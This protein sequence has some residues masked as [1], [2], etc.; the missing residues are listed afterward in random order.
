MKFTMNAKENQIKAEKVLLDTMGIGENIKLTKENFKKHLSRSIRQL[1][2]YKELEEKLKNVDKYKLPYKLFEIIRREKDKKIKTPK[3]APTDGVLI[4][5]I[6]NGPLECAGR[7]MIASELL[8]KHKVDHAVVSAPG[9]SFII[10]NLGGNTLSYLDANNNLYFTFPRNALVGF[11]GTQEISKSRLK[12]YVPRSNDKIDGVSSAFTDFVV[13]PPSE[14][15]ARQYLGNVAA[16]LA[17]NK[18][19]YSNNTVSHFPNKCFRRRRRRQ[20]QLLRFGNPRL[21]IFDLRWYPLWL[22]RKCDFH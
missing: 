16:A 22:N 14:G 12:E 8:Q 13:M 10:I 3:D 21:N 17:G 18:E 7:V 5:S 15:V 2:R 9:H 11:K 20:Q 19:F 6:Q 1:Q 4:R